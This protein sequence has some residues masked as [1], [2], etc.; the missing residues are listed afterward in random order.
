MW[1]WHIQPKKDGVVPASEEV[2]SGKGKGVAL[3]GVKV[4]SWHMRG[5]VLV[6]EVD[7]D[8]YLQMLMFE[9]DRHSIH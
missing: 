8:S 5:V 3:A 6:V 1:S 2:G 7:I 9:M 4:W